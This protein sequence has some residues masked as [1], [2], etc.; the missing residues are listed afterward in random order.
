MGSGHDAQVLEDMALSPHKSFLGTPVPSVRDRYPDLAHPGDQSVLVQT[1]APAA[2]PW[3]HAVLGEVGR[4][5]G[6]PLL[7]NHGALSPVWLMYWS[8]CGR[9]GG[10]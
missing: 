3:L 8:M 5:T 4:V 7:L 2:D 9:W 1:L 6:L 10:G